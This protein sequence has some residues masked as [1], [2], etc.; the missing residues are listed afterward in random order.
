MNI[1]LLS[2]GTGIIILIGLLFWRFRLM[3]RKELKSELRGD[4]A[5]QNNDLLTNTIESRNDIQ[6]EFAAYQAGRLSNDAVHSL[7]GGET[8]QSEPSKAPP[9]RMRSRRLRGTGRVP[10]KKR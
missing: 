5:V 6:K 2:F 3:V 10:K 8:S 9:A 1:Y 7:F 4:L